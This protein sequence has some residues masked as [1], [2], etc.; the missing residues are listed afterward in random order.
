MAG[1]PR[2]VTF[3]IVRVPDG[4][5]PRAWGKKFRDMYGF[6]Y[7]GAP[8]G[9]SSELLL[10]P[11]EIS[12]ASLRSNLQAAGVTFREFRGSPEQMYG[13]HG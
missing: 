8:P 10:W 2:T 11:N 7:D 5:P 6:E 9:R 1:R 3:F 12:A 4:L 13:V